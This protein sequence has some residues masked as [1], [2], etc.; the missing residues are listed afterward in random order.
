V[1]RYG[2]CL[3]KVDKRR[4]E[5]VT[6]FH[7]CPLPHVAKN[8]ARYLLAQS[9]PCVLQGWY[10]VPVRIGTKSFISASRTTTPASFLTQTE[11]LG[12]G[13]LRMLNRAFAA[14]PFL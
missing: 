7:R 9:E 12:Y 1:I 8:V 3:K 4:C 6:A 2:I 14:S 11:S 10:R 13:L 5:K